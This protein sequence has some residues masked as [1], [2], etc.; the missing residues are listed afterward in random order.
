[1]IKLYVLRQVQIC[2]YLI[3][4]ESSRT[5]LWCNGWNQTKYYIGISCFTAKYA[6][7][8]SKS[9]VWLALN[10]NNVAEWS[11]MYKSKRILIKLNIHIFVPVSRHTV[12]SFGYLLF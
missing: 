4:S 1:M 7:L 11:D 10:H 9:K 8:R 6:A 12:L 2:G 5:Y 3:R